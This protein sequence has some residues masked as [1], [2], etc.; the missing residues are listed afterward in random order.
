MLVLLLFTLASAWLHWVGVPDF[1][2]DRIRDE[3]ARDGI[4]FEA[5]QVRFDLFE[6]VVITDV[7]W[8]LNPDDVMPTLEA[9]KVILE[10]ALNNIGRPNRMLRG[11]Q[12]TE[13]RL[14]TDLGKLAE[15]ETRLAMA[16]NVVG[17]PNV[18]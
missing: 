12:V 17:A 2:V 3:A 4:M 8:Y 11:F 5:D 16:E 13:A 18:V 9:E 1:L 7:L 14:A 10:L 6:G 15:K